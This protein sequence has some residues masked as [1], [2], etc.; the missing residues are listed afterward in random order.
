MTRD[1]IAAALLAGGP[2]VD[3]AVAVAA[4]TLTAWR[5][6]PTF[7]RKGYANQSRRMAHRAAAALV[8]LLEAAAADQARRSDER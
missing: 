8:Q 2:D 6:F 4:D 7:I 1:Q 3:R 5:S